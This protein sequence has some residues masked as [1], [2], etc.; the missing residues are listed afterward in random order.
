MGGGGGGGGG[1]RETQRERYDRYDLQ[2][3]EGL[4]RYKTLIIGEWEVGGGGGGGRGWEKI[5]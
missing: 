4:K 2:K 3:E 5:Q 1:E